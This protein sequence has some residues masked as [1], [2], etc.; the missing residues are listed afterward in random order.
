MF[1]KNSSNVNDYEVAPKEAAETII[2]ASV[3]VEGNFVCDGSMIINGEVKGHIAT[4]SFLE[5]GQSAVIVADVLAENAKIAGRIDGDVAIDN[6]LEIKD[7]AVISGNIKCSKLLVSAGAVING[8]CQMTKEQP[9]APKKEETSLS[10][11]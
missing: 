3:K 8:N 2:G 9:Q 1:A 5:V 10:N 6:F 4:K 7:T 11:E